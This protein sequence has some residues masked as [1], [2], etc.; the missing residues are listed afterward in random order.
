LRHSKENERAT[1]NAELV[2]RPLDVGELLGEV[3]RYL[4][5]VDLFRALG[6]EPTWRG[7][8]RPAAAESFLSRS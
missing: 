4:D 8:I 6:H 1:E 3:A 2:G 5:A 7:V